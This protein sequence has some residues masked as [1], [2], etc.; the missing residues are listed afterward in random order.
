MRAAVATL[1]ATVVALAATASSAGEGR[2]VIVI[3]VKLCTP[4]EVRSTVG[5][6]VAAHNAGDGRRLDRVFA[7]EPDFRW[8]STD[9][10]GKRLLPA[11]ADRASLSRYFA[12]RHAR[13]ERLRLTSLRVNGNT[14]AAGTLKSYG[15]FQF[16]LERKASDLPATDYQGKGA[17][18]CHR[19]TPDV[20]IVWA[21]GRAA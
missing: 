18:H 11:A 20:L 16:T 9:A 14:I 17:L 7:P 19:S 13:H 5:R 10:P 8:Y 1:G 2:Q 6:F 4:A 12:S 21:M 3:G 15:N